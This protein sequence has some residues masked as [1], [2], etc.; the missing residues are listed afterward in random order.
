MVA[1]ARGARGLTNTHSD[2]VTRSPRGLWVPLDYPQ[3]P[4]GYERRTLTKIFWL[5]L[6]PSAPWGTGHVFHSTTVSP[7]CPWTATTCAM[8]S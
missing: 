4:T 3:A 8:L 2:H 7:P 5:P 6:G 1:G